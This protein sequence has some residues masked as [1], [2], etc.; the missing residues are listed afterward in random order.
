MLSIQQASKAQAKAASDKVELSKHPLQFLVSSM[1]AGAYVGLA[2]VLMICATAPLFAANSPGRV[3]LSGCVFAT[4]L[5]VI[6]FG[7]AE[8]VTG[9]MMTLVHGIAKKLI[10]ARDFVFVVLFCFIGN[11]LGSIV[12]SLLVTG[13]GVIEPGTPNHNLLKAMLNIRAN[14]T[15][16][17]EF[18][19]GILCN[20][21]VCLAVWICAR[22]ETESG[23]AIA[24]FWCMVCFVCSGYEHVVA[25]M[26]TFTLGLF[27]AEAATTWLE[28][29]RQCVFVGLGNLVG[30]SLFAGGAYVLL[31]GRGTDTAGAAGRADKKS[32]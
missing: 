1:L 8:L 5:T 20:F 19:R 32:K 25:N 4:A 24:I 27:S 31:A 29:G 28:F 9:T 14:E 23:K 18:L 12:V 3:F 11:L 15:N 30:G 7:G 16:L 26:T 21:M 22:L 6:V 10:N 13:A 17:Q 2:V